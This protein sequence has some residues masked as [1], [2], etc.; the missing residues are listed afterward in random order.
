MRWRPKIVNIAIRFLVPR[1]QVKLCATQN[2]GRINTERL[3][4]F[5]DLKIEKRKKLSAATRF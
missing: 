2:V 3:G 1:I 4:G 5:R